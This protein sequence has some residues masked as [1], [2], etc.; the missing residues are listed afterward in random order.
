MRPRCL[1]IQRVR[2][3]REVEAHSRGASKLGCCLAGDSEAESLVEP[4]RARV[5][6]HVHTGRACS[7]R[8][9]DNILD[10]QPTHSEPHRIRFDK[11][12]VEFARSVLDH[13]DH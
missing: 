8:A 1:P 11:Q 7:S 6:R 4:N 10:E 3:T 12:I 13:E 9:C 5:R 2:G